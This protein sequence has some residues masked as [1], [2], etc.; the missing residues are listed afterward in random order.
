MNS[1]IKSLNLTDGAVLT[2]KKLADRMEFDAFAVMPES[3]MGEC[4]CY[5]AIY[6]EIPCPLDGAC[7]E[8]SLDPCDCNGPHG[9][10][11]CHPYK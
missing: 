11:N 2:L 10:I 3:R 8:F 6:V 5:A 1:I 7:P 4:S 9:Y